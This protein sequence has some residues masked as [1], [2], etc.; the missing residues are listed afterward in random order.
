MLYALLFL[1]SPALARDCASDLPG[2]AKLF[3]R[4]SFP[5]TWRETTAND[6]K[7]LVVKISERDGRLHLEFDKTKEGLWAKGTA[8]VCA[9]KKSVEAA[10]S[11]KQIKLGDAA[12]WILRMSMKGGA[13]FTLEQ[14][15]PG[16]LH[17][18][19]FGWS[20][21]FVPEENQT[22]ASGGGP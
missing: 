1:L 9:G 2:L 8:D 12:P 4:E 16:K 14:P 13:T 19:T 18:G 20:G 6:G 15:E 22:P 17:I 7:P 11:K 21:D 10:I 5:A 3:K